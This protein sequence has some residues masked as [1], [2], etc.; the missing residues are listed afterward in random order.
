MAFEKRLSAEGQELRTPPFVRHRRCRGK[1][2]L[3]RADAPR[4]A[5]NQF[6]YSREALNAIVLHPRI[7][8]A[9][10]QLL[11]GEIRFYGD[12]S[13]AKFGTSPTSGDQ[14]LHLD[15]KNHSLF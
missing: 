3:A 7:L 2:H 4:L 10:T 5:Q 11:G 14:E 15:C 1:D 8:T 9:V 6:P 13:L 12:V